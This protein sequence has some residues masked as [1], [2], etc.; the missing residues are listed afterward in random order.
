M[1]VIISAI[2]LAFFTFYS[3][4]NSQ[5][6]TQQTSTST[7]LPTSTIPLPLIKQPNVFKKIQGIPIAFGDLNSDKRA[8]IVVLKDDGT[9]IDVFYQNEEDEKFES[10][11]WCKCDKP[12]AQIYLAEINTDVQMN[13]LVLLIDK[14]SNGEKVYH[15]KGLLK[16]S[17][18]STG[19]ISTYSIAKADALTTNGT[20]NSSSNYSP[21]NTYQ[22][23]QDTLFGL[24]N[25]TATTSS[26][27]ILNEKIGDCKLKDLGV[28]LKS[29]PLLFDLDG[30]LQVD[31][32]GLDIDN[33]V[34]V[35]S[36]PPN[37]NQSEMIKDSIKWRHISKEYFGKI[38][39]NS[40]IDINHDFAADIVF[41][42]EGNVMYAFAN[43][44]ESKNFQPS[45]KFEKRK[46]ITYGQSTLVD[47]DGDGIID[48]ILPVCSKNDCSVLQLKLDTSIE[49]I[50]KFPSNENETLF[51]TE[52]NFAENYIFPISLRPADFDGDGYTDF[53]TVAKDKD[54]QN[55][56][57]YL[58]NIEDKS[59]HKDA[60]SKRTFEIKVNKIT[61]SSQEVKLVVPFDLNEDGKIDLLIGTSQESAKPEDMSVTALMNSQMEDTCFLKVIVTNGHCEHNSKPTA[62]CGN[63]AIGPSVCFELDNDGGLKGCAGQIPQSSHF[64][65]P[66]PYII[67]GLGQTAH[68]VEKVKISIP[69][70]G[71]DGLV[72][73]RVLDQ[74]VPDAQIIIIPTERDNPQNWEYKLFLSPMSRL[75]LSTLIVL[76][77]ICLVLILIIAILHRKELKEDAAEHAEYRR[78][79]PESR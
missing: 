5:S 75:A 67:F 3:V 1:N 46:D 45:V 13:L 77:V 18:K 8:D 61:N 66:L 42:S 62:T 27:L 7:N 11:G 19:S 23:S 34:S 28:V 69:G 33:K 4:A 16:D 6:T 64:A 35:W 74:I 47:I 24:A 2:L 50:F 52:I 78:H 54:R 15:L 56:I 30:D 38:H 22:S 68:F 70:F 73:S 37:H 14:Q 26:S 55:V 48:H 59:K 53:V 36:C 63:T 12:I 39:S 51:L 21:K 31:I 76:S 20:Y 17:L 29:Q 57:L 40:F 79:W 44:D 49:T 71:K 65:L 9:G 25:I 32:M 58:H 72:R 10:N 60:P 41:S 43:P